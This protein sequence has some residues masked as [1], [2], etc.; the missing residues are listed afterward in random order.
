MFLLVYPFYLLRSLLLYLLY[1]MPEP[2]G[3]PCTSFKLFLHHISI[4]R[5]E[6]Y[7]LL[8]LRDPEQFLKSENLDIF[9]TYCT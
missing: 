6:H 3:A 5:Y 9:S 7:G 2:C 4:L 1:D 8:F